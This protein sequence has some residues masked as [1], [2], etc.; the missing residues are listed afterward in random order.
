MSHAECPFLSDE[1]INQYNCRACRCDNDKKCYKH[2]KNIRHVT[3]FC[4]NIPELRR[5]PQ[6]SGAASGNGESTMK[7]PE[8]SL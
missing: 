2:H 4:F 5:S 6:S 3:G 1:Y 7:K 8:D